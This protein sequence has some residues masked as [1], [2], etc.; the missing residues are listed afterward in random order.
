MKLK[1]VLA[2]SA[3]VALAG[4]PANAQTVSN[5]PYAVSSYLGRSFRAVRKALTNI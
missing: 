4:S 5:G 3:I 2:A 1:V